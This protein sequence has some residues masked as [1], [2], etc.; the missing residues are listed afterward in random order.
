MNRH[1]ANQISLFFL[2]VGLILTGGPLVWMLITAFTSPDALAATPPR[3]EVLRQTD[4]GL[5]RIPLV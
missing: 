1:I 5:Q 4:G 2:A 3:A